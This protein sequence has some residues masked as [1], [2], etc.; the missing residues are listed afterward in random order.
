MLLD[1]SLVSSMALG[2]LRSGRDTEMG[3]FGCGGLK[4]LRK[5]PVESLPFT[6]ELPRMYFAWRLTNA[7][8]HTCF[9]LALCN[10]MLIFPVWSRV[11]N[12]VWLPA[13]CRVVT[14]AVPATLLSPCLPTRLPSVVYYSLN[15]MHLQC[16]LKWEVPTGALI[17]PFLL[18]SVEHMN[19]LHLWFCILL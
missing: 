4:R 18:L 10:M 13:W 17:P 12:L 7:V 9:A 11:T 14:V 19:L 6:C 1:R 3:T 8:L 5:V 2:A 16:P 15:V